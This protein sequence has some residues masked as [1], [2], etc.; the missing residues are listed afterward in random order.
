MLSYCTVGN[1]GSWKVGKIE[2]YEGAHQG[3]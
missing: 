1:A 3:G 2:I